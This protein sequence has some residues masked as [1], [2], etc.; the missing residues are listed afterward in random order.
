MLRGPLLPLLLCLPFGA[1]TWFSSAER[2]LVHSEPPGARILVDG[3]DTGRTTPAS[4]PIGGLF[5]SDHVISLEKKGYRRAHRRTCQYTEGYTSKWIDGAFE[6]VM[7]PLPLFWTAG[8]FVTPFGV[9][10]AVIPGELWVV[11]ERED[12]PKLGFDL[13]LPPVAAGSGRP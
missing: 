11:L 13:L 8:D 10:S 5:G 2:V 6:A 9:R 1:C 3:K 7:P 12:A 4:L